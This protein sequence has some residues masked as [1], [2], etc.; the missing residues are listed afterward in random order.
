M[1]VRRG[2]RVRTVVEAPGE[3][4]GP[5][6]EGAR[7]GTVRVYRGERLVRTRAARDR[8]RRA[9]GGVPA[10]RLRG[11]LLPVVMVAAGVGIC[12]RGAAPR[13]GVRM[14]RP[15]RRVTRFGA[16]RCCGMLV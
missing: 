16:R 5:L 2:E 1:T 10:P 4:S 14:R 12:A 6:D 13:A 9:E 7:V 11:F 15:A 3:L 8:R